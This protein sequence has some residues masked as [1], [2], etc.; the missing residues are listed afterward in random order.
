M[1]DSPDAEAEILIELANAKMPFGKYAGRYL[2]DLPETYVLW[3]K[4]KGYPPGKLGDQLRM[5]EDIHTNGLEY[6]LRP[7][8]RGGY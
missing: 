7:L 6:L 5:I 3:F 8:R 1:S 2:V 4:G